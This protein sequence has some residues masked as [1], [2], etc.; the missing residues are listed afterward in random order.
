MAIIKN[1]L[2]DLIVNETDGRPRFN[3]VRRNNTTGETDIYLRLSSP[4]LQNPSLMTAAIFNTLLDQESTTSEWLSKIKAR[5]WE[6]RTG[7]AHDMIAYHGGDKSL[8]SLQNCELGFDNK[9]NLSVGDSNGIAHLL[10]WSGW[11]GWQQ[12]I[13]NGTSTNIYSAMGE[14]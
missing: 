6:T 3:I 10:A 1:P 9:G 11:G 14:R 4:V 8:N 5:D 2:K 13:F 7:S 12:F